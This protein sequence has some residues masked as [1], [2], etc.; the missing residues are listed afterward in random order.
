ME[1]V[2]MYLSADAVRSTLHFVSKNSA[3][4]GGIVFDYYDRRLQDGEGQTPFYKANTALF[5]SWGE[6]QTFGIPGYD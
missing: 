3:A 6:P 5:R 4:G 1:G 2:T